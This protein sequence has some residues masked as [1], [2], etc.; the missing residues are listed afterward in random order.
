M[1]PVNKGLRDAEKELKQLYSHYADLA[2]CISRQNVFTATCKRRLPSLIC[3]GYYLGERVFRSTFQ[4]IENEIS[5]TIEYIHCL[6]SHKI[7]PTK[8]LTTQEVEYIYD[9]L[10]MKQISII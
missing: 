1:K 2:S 7:N 4:K 9:Q 6:L 5:A 8:E 3:L 10:V